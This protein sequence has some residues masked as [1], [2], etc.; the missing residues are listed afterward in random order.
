MP[1]APGCIRRL[2]PCSIKDSR[3]GQPPAVLRVPAASRSSGCHAGDDS[4]HGW[5][6]SFLPI[7]SHVILSE[8][9]RSAAND[10]GSKDLI[11]VSA[12][13][14]YARELSRR[15]RI[16]LYL[17]LAPE[18]ERGP[19][20]QPVL[21]YR[22]LAFLAATLLRAAFSFFCFAVG[23]SVDLARVLGLGESP[24]ASSY[25]SRS[26]LVRGSSTSSRCLI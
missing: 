12:T 7:Q 16:D 3:N 4:D 26:Q 5:L 25:A 24:S 13:H 2:W 19:R 22:P 20:H 21:R 1:R 17:T 14:G 8:A 23:C 18:N 10:G 11:S 9:R 6:L 15:T